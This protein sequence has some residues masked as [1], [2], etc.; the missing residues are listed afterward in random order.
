MLRP[1]TQI[2]HGHGLII[3]CSLVAILLGRLRLTTTEAL[4]E[5]DSFAQKIFC[6]KNRRFSLV[7]RYGE[8][9]LELAVQEV[10]QKCKA[11]PLMKDPS[12]EER[13]TGKAFVCAMP[14]QNQGVPRRIRSYNSGDDWDKNIT[15]VQAARATSA[16]P[17]FFK[18]LVIENEGGVKEELIDAAMG[19]NNPAAEVLDEAGMQF[20]NSCKL[21]CF[22]SLGTG[23]RPKNM[24]S[25][26]AIGRLLDIGKLLK[27]V[28]TDSEAKREEMDRKFTDHE[29]TYFRFS[30]P[31]AASKVKMEA[32]RDIPKLK[33]MTEEYLR[34]AEAKA[35]IEKIVDV[36]VNNRTEG[37]TIGQACKFPVD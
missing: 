21:G 22:L 2:W 33:A 10:V 34:G 9:A 5:Y 36:L 26:D 14:K 6:T 11:T 28:T 19:V 35:N 16:A 12:V 30:V 1:E 17:T 24:E 27:E 25:T 4:K 3:L 15:V 29:S 37:V 32:Y 31:D 23:T 18:P 7:S 20:D 8:E 13:A